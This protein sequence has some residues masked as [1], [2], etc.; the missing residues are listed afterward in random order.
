M[1]QGKPRLR[2]GERDSTPDGRN[3]RA[4]LQRSMNLFIKYFW[5]TGHLHAKEWI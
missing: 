1:S 2:D 3:Y 5:E 4:T